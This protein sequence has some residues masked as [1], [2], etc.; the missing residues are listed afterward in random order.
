ME[1]TPFYT[2]DI[3][4]IYKNGKIFEGPEYKL[5]G[6]GHLI[7]SYYKDGQVSAFDVNIFAM[8]Y[9]N[10]LSFQK[11]KNSLTISELTSPVVMNLAVK[12]DIFE[13][14]IKKDKQLLGLVNIYMEPSAG[15]PNSRTVYYQ[16]DNIVQAYISRV[17]FKKEMEEEIELSNSLIIRMMNQLPNQQKN[18]LTEVFDYYYAL[19]M[20]EDLNGAMEEGGFSSDLINEDTYLGYL[21]YSEQGSPLDGV[22]IQQHP[23]SSLSVSSYEDGI[24]QSTS[25][26]QSIAE[27]L[28]KSNSY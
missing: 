16:K 5:A 27:F 23:D 3:K 12:D 24:L 2:Y 1:S 21:S 10:R 11:Q 28:E 7:V 9:F 15:S 4:S 20:L 18:T 19:F 8:H 17:E 6:K 13:A 25:T 26:Y 22:L 14:E